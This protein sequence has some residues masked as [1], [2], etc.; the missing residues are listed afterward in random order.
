MSYEV[1]DNMNWNRPLDIIPN[2]ISCLFIYKWLQNRDADVSMVTPR[3]CF[4]DFINQYGV[5]FAIPFLDLVRDSVIQGAN[6]QD[7]LKDEVIKGGILSFVSM[8]TLEAAFA[9]EILK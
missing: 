7:N 9:G 2:P 5:D 8:E 6:L 3:W 4:E 1:L